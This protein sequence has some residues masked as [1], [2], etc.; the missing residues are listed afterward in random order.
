MT[1]SLALY[2]RGLSDPIADI[3]ELEAGPVC[4][5][6]WHGGQE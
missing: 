2:R 3:T 6:G 5:E 1:E 4:H